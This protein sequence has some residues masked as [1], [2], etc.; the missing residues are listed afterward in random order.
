MGKLGLF[1]FAGLLGLLSSVGRFDSR[2]WLTPSQALAQAARDSDEG[3][4]IVPYVPT[5]QEVVERML[6]LAGVTKGDM[7]YD[8]GTG[9]GRIVVTAAKKY[10]DMTIGYEIDPDRIKESHENIKYA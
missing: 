5:P 3:K 2:S 4:K 8:L 1:L 7:D 6:E 9:D 10:R